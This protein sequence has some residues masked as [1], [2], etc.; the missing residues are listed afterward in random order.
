MWT[1]QKVVCPLWWENLSRCG[2]SQRCAPVGLSWTPVGCARPVPLFW[3]HCYRQSH[4]GVWVSRRMLMLSMHLTP[5]C[6]IQIEHFIQLSL[7]EP[8]KSS[9]WKYA[10]K[11]MKRFLQLFSLFNWVT[12][13]Q[14]IT[15]AFNYVTRS[16][17]NVPICEKPLPPR[18]PG[19]FAKNSTWCL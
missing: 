3:E 8:F 10:Y 5:I 13:K 11:N 18:P 7:Y 15:C 12:G 14:Q 9:C 19:I 17:A 6:G 4:V 1:H 2:R 16:G